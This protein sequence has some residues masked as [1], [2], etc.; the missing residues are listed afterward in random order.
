M[1][2]TVL[3]IALLFSLGITAWAQAPQAFNYQG[4]ARN[5]LG[6]PMANTMLG[7]RL[8]VHDGSAIGTI[9]YQET[10]A[11]TTNAFGLYNVS[12]GTGTV[13]SGTVTAIN[14]GTGT[15]FLQVEID[16]AG[17]SSYVDAGTSQLLSVPY[18][19]FADRA[20]TAATANTATSAGSLTGTVTMGGDV[21][22]T[23]AASSVV[24]LNGNAVSAAVPT[25]GQVLSWNAGSSTWV[26]FTLPTTGGTVTSITAGTGLSGGVIT[27]S[28]TISMPNVGTAGTYG[29]ATVVPVITTDAQ[30]R[31]TSVTNTPITG[32]NWGSQTVQTD[33]TLTG[34]GTTGSKLSIAQQGA[35]VGQAL[36]W[37]GTTWQP[38][39][40]PAPT[41]YSAGTGMTLTGSTFSAQTTNALWNA[42]ELQGK[43]ISATAPVSGQVLSWSGTNWTPT[44]VSG[45]GTVTSVTAGT[46]LSGGTFSTSGTVSMPNVGTAATYGSATQVPVFTTDAQG[47]VTGVTNTTIA[48]GGTGTVTS[49]ATTAGQLTGGPITSSGTLGLAT[50]GTAGTY[51]S[52]T[53]VPVLTTDA[54]GRVTTVTNTTISG[55]APGGA[56][57]GDLTGTYPNPAVGVGAITNAKVAAGAGI[58]YSKL[59]LTNSIA[60]ADHSATGAPSATTFLRG[61]N[62]WSTPSTSPTG[63]ASG[64]LTGTYPGPTVAAGAITNAKVAAGAGIAYSKLNLT[65]SIAIADH[66]AT[67]APSATTFLR[68]DNTWNTPTGVTPGGPAG[69]D[70]TGTYPNPTLAPDGVVAG[71]YGTATQVP[72][73]IVDAKGRVT[74]ASNTTITTGVAGTINYV[75]KFTSATAIGNSQ[76]FDNGTSVG[77]GTITPVATNKLHVLSTGSAIYSNAVHGI[78]IA[79]SSLLF[80]SPTAVYG[81][82][83]T[84]NGVAGS[85]TSGIGVAGLTSGG[86]SQ[87]GIYGVATAAGGTGVWGTLS[88]GFAGNAGYF[89]GGTGGYGVI[90]NAGLSGFGTV[91][92][93]AMLHVNGSKDLSVT[94][95]GS[96]FGHQALIAQTSTTATSVLGCAVIGYAA[97][98][99][100][101]N[102]GLHGYAYGP[103]G[104]GFNLGAFLVGSSSATTTGNNYG[105]YAVANSGAN[106]FGIYATETG[107]GYAGYFNG[108]IY[109]TTGSFGVK[110]FKIDDP[111]DPANKY[112]Y[113]SSI[114]SD[115]MMNIYRGHVTTDV[116]GDA[117]VSLPS[118]VTLINKDF[119][120]QLTCV[121]Q[122]AQAIVAEEMSGNQFKIKTDKPNVKVSWQVSGVRKDPVANAYRI[123][124]EVDKPASEKGTYLQPEV[125]GQPVEKMTGY[126]DPKTGG[127]PTTEGKQASPTAPAATNVTAH[128]ST[129]SSTEIK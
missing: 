6:T 37:N 62:T 49:V 122:F 54:Y 94:L 58:A 118:Y 55:T 14:W 116:N 126:L 125:Y 7:L 103:G 76:L 72:T 23:N 79:G 74:S 99:T 73:I 119:D 66:S 59:N 22:G 112:L 28:G 63:A 127:R 1:K 106:N 42:N 29:T 51:G 38:N 128:P 101:E 108:A 26:P 31:V 90:V 81:E 35:T 87:A 98:S 47:R 17:G 8:S 70:L 117:T 20:R 45:T 105:L 95:G 93:A 69:G 129:N 33:A 16:P 2:K 34:N 85:S 4:V 102:H 111:R 114:E 25:A 107:T 78:Q 36:E 32:D 46:G 60:I 53:Q 96:S 100:Y 68:G 89:D 57:G 18:A 121:G 110:P 50:A 48:A 92:P 65:G 13:V 104:T 77:L 80:T 115:E 71:T 3:S 10:Q 83:S 43:S 123:V 67:G 109:A 27:S 41:T 5:S 24:K 40:I 61:D 21:T 15:K 97:N 88:G 86:A 19:V 124:V 75:P 52:A 9:V 82:S 113:H 56:A 39:T 30:G 91:T 84:G 12:I 44:S 64:D 11:P 120:Y